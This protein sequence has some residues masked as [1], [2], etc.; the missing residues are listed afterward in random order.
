MRAGRSRTDFVQRYAFTLSYDGTHYAGWQIQPNGITIQEKLEAAAATLTG[1][2]VTMHGSGRTDRGVHARGQVAHADL[3]VR[4]TPRKLTRAMNALLPADIRIRRT[5]RVDAGFH[6]RKSAVAK[7]YRYFI[8]NHPIVPPHVRLYRTPVHDRLN[9]DLMSRAAEQLAGTHDFA[10]FT[11]N[12][13]RFVEG[14]VR[15]VDQLSVR[16]HG[17]EIC[18]IV[19]GEG[20]LYKMVRS[21]AGWLIRVGTGAVPAEMTAEVLASRE[22]TARVPTA[23]AQGLF[24]W[25]VFY[26]APA[27]E[28]GQKERS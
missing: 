8:W 2:Q 17:H 6:A 5:V 20:F 23:A 26:E 12:P 21:L 15:R 10:S 7:E 19:R 3:A 14:T 24:L 18:F 16:R 28:Q 1:A 11:A 4:M 13:N 9:C 22:R 25:K 27:N